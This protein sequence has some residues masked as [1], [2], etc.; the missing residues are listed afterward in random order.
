MSLSHWINQPWSCPTLWV[1]V[2]VS[3]YISLLFNTFC[4][5]LLGFGFCFFVFSDVLFFVTK[6]IPWIYLPD[7]ISYQWLFDIPLHLFD[8]FYWIPSKPRLSQSFSKSHLNVDF[9]G[10]CLC[11]WFGGKE[12]RQE[13]GMW[14]PVLDH[15]RNM[16]ERSKAMIAISPSLVPVNPADSRTH[17]RALGE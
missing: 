7:S 12:S 17:H 1:G 15:G 2:I 5:G 11:F 14:V 9:R 10:K 3:I 8:M 16:W 4:F 6:S 13:G